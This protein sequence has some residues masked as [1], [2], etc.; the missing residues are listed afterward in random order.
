MSRLLEK[1]AAFTNLVEDGFDVNDAS[2]LVKL[3]EEEDEDNRRGR[4]SRRLVH[5]GAGAG[6]GAVGGGALS[7][8]AGYRKGS[9]EA[10]DYENFWKKVTGSPSPSKISR[11]ISKKNTNR[12][13]KRLGGAGILAGV[14]GGAVTGASLP[15]RDH[16]KAAALSNLLTTATTS[17]TPLPSS[18]PSREIFPP[19]SRMS[20]LHEKVAAFVNLV[21]EGYSLEDA[22]F[23]VKASSTKD[24]RASFSKHL[25]E[26]EL[27]KATRRAYAREAL[28]GTLG[29]LG[30]GY[31]GHRV[32]GRLGAVLGS[33]WGGLHAL[34]HGGA[35]SWEN[36]AQKIREGKIGRKMDSMNESIGEREHGIQ[37]TALAGAIAGA[38]GGGTVGLIDGYKKGRK[39]GK[40]YLEGV[41]KSK[42]DKLLRMLR[43]PKGEIRKVIKE[44]TRASMRHAGEA[45]AVWGSLGGAVGG[46]LLPKRS[47]EKVS[48][49]VNLLDNGYSFD[50]A[51]GLVKMAS[52]I[53]RNN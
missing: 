3:A 38:V 31:V 28:E 44:G 6:V 19:E 20:R 2:I 11:M 8:L 22:A 27:R 49:L 10:R 46:T 24:E 9:R 14:L 36:T 30:G 33:T 1:V 52:S 32:G 39:S 40:A 42:K 35:S 41:R 43:P 18:G 26:E 4:D 13:M 15:V 23:L 53:S 7:T 12:Y 5:A 21:G 17:T 45:G 51:I 29:A 48:A 25:N 47:H 37:D 34:N 50:D 16:E